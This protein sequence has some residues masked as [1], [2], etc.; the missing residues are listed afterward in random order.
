MM[1]CASSAASAAAPAVQDSFMVGSDGAVA[2]LFRHYLS[3]EAKSSPSP[4][5]MSKQVCL[6]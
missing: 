4:K 2:D 6:S 5:Y 3:I 1:S